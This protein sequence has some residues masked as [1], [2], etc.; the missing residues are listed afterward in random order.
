MDILQ[1]IRMPVSMET[2]EDEPMVSLIRDI[3]I[4]M[5]EDPEREGL[6]R[7]PERVSRMY[8]E[9][10]S[11]YQTNLDQLVNGALF[12]SPH[13]D[14]VL[15]R[16]IQFYSLCEHH[17][18][19]FFGKVQVAY[20]PNGKIIGLSKIPRLVEMY[21]RRLQVQERMTRQIADTLQDILQPAGV[22][23]LAEGAHLCAMMRGVRQGEARM[24]TVARLGVFQTDENIYRDFL[25]QLSI[26]SSRD[27]L[28]E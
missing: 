12:E 9:V 13:N 23:V 8:T 14:Q 22:V 25:S 21:A 17:L 6:L 11:G 7:T 19:P 16:N 20:I 26:N 24:Q 3:L 10:L 4:Q 15:V 28:L 5:G 18:L 27:T 1:D 2:G